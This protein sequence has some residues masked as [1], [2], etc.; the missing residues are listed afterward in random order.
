MS[1]TSIIA[2]NNATYTEIAA[3]ASS[4]FITNN[5]SSDVYIVFSATQPAD[6]DKGHV[7]EENDDPFLLAANPQ[8]CWGKLLESSFLTGNVTVTIGNT[9]AGGDAS[10]ANQQLILNVLTDVKAPYSA[11]HSLSDFALNTSAVLHGESTA[12]GG[13]IVRVKVNPSGTLATESTL[14]AG[15]VVIGKVGID[16]TTDGTT[17]RIAAN[18][19]KVS[20]AAITLGQK[21]AANSIPVVLSSDGAVG[22][23]FS[24][25]SIAKTTALSS[26]LVVKA[27]AGTLLGFTVYN[28][29]A[30]AQFIQIHNT[31]SLPA[32]SSIPIDILRVEGKSSNSYEGNGIVGDAYST[33]ITLCNSSTAATKTIG[34]ADCWIV[35]RFR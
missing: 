33:G 24:T 19:D 1:N 21:T 27:S 11:S 13:S 28:D 30:N 10:A 2:L 34:S 8:K 5:S 32:D 6:S 7:F 14:T 15:S 35:A 17:N 26:S 3:A 12:G 25:P 16:Q 31:T 4:G 18:L 23:V 20:G 29:N 9:A 22:V